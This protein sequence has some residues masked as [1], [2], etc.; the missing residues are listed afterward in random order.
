[1][2]GNIPVLTEDTPRI[3]FINGCHFTFETLTSFSSKITTKRSL[4]NLFK[5][6]YQKTKGNEDQTFSSLEQ[7]QKGTESCFREGGSLDNGNAEK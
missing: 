6:I 1:M 2:K 3:V 5:F 7:I 4:T